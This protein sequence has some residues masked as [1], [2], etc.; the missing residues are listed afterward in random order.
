LPVRVDEHSASASFNN[1]VLDIELDRTDS[2]A[3]IDLS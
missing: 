3:D 1:G 2:S